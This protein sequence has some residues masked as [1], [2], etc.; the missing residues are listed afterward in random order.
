MVHNIYQVIN[1]HFP[2]PGYQN[3]MPAIQTH[4]NNL[5]I[6][7]LPMPQLQSVFIP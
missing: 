5:N 3:K 2:S 1:N 7:F 6:I 4:A